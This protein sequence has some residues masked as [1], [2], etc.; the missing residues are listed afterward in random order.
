MSANANSKTAYIKAVRKAVTAFLDAK[1]SLDAL[2]DEWTYYMNGEVANEDFIGE[3]DGLVVTDLTNVLGTTLTEINGM[4][5]GHW[6]NLYT[7]KQ[8]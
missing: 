6:T 8:T 5:T 7:L 1:E 3:N 4:T 2:E